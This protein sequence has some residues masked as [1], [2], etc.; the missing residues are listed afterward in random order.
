MIGVQP[1]IHSY[2]EVRRCTVGR[3]YITLVL[4]GRNCVFVDIYTQEYT[5]SD[6]GNRRIGRGDLDP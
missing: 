1:V 3:Q 4:I 2:H 6:D 5:H